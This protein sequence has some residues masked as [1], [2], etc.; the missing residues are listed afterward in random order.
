MLK[1]IGFVHRINNS[2]LQSFSA[3]LGINSTKDLVYYVET[4]GIA[5]LR[6]GSEV[7]AESF[8]TFY[9]SRP[10]V[11]M[12]FFLITTLI[13]VVL[14]GIL[15]IYLIF[16]VILVFKTKTMALSLFGCISSDL[17]HDLTFKCEQFVKIHLEELGIQVSDFN[18]RGILDF[19]VS[20]HNTVIRPS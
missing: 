9:L 6:V 15:Q 20:I 3:P 17:L 1:Y 19:T 16:Y 18:F 2:S 10:D 14:V 11:F 7:I 8:M 13:A 12:K 5:N 4:N